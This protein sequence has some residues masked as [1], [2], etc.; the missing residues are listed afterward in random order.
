MGLASRQKRVDEILNKML[1]PVPNHD[2]HTP[3]LRCSWRAHLVQFAERIEE[4]EF[5]Q[6]RTT[7]KKSIF[8]QVFGRVHW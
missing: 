7:D 1:T 6:T 5:E 3:C 2:E 8:E 4:A